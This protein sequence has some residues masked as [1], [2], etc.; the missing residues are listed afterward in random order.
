MQ[1]SLFAEVVEKFFFPEGIRPF[2]EKYNGKTQSPTLLH[3][4][5]LDE[6]Y[7]PDLKWGSKSINHSVVSADVVSL[8]SPL[9]LKKRDRLSIA[10]G[11]LPKLG[12]KYAKGEKDINDMNVIKSRSGNIYQLAL[13]VF[14]DTA[15]TERSMDVAKEIL[16]RRG[17]STGITLVTDSDNDGVGIR[18]SF[19]FKEENSFN[20]L[21]AAWDK[22]G[23]TPQDDLQQ[24]FD[25]AAA[26]GNVISDVLMTL[27][28]FNAFRKSPQ[29]RLLAAWSNSQAITD[30]DLLPVASRSAFLEI[31][32]DEYGAEFHIVEGSFRVQDPDGADRPVESWKEGNVVAVPAFKVGRLVYGTLAEET[33]PVEGVKYLK[34]G[35]HVLVSKYSKTDP[36]E[37]FT[38]GQAICLP[39]IDNGEQIYVLHADEGTETTVTGATGATGATGGK[40]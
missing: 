17:L 30:K 36:L 5:M 20:C 15:K 8:D 28:Y 19:G 33:N 21:A 2:I 1:Q 40:S 31:L 4:Q 23:S 26:D 35:T 13:K 6:E 39:V 27:K 11:E 29:G 25:K 10:G 38:A 18:V 37:E 32:R 3:K 24:L 16:F 14:D 7:S 22:S 34:L 9:P 12:V